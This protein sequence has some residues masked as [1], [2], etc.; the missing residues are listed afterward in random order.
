MAGPPSCMADALVLLMLIPSDH[1]YPLALRDRV[2]RENLLDPFDS[3]VRRRLRGHAALH[4][5]GPPGAP[6][7]LVADLSIGRVIDVELRNGRAQQALLGVRLAMRV[8]RP[9][10]VVL[11]DRCHG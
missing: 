8:R 4:D 1:A 2:F 11:H 6:D 10:W 5:V 9:P 3:L 7:M